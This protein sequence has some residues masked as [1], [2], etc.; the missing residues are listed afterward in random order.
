M[1][2]LLL[3]TIVSVSCHKD[4]C[5][6][7]MA[8]WPS[9]TNIS[10]F[11]DSLSTNALMGLPGSD[12]YSE[13][14]KMK[15]T[16]MTSDPAMIIL[17]KTNDDIIKCLQFAHQFNIRIVVQS[18]GH[19]FQVIGQYVMSKT[20]CILHIIFVSDVQCILLVINVM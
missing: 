20:T 16:R 11:G 12:L 1:T 18:S 10:N 7:K 8:C 14:V 6:P 13:K 4:Y 9:G 5:I 19:D 2:T 3:L 17:V 15:N